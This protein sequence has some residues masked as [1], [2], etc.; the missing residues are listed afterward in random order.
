[1]AVITEEYAE[2]N[3]TNQK[4]AYI[5]QRKRRKTATS[6]SLKAQKPLIIRW[7]IAM[8]YYTSKLQKSVTTSTLLFFRNEQKTHTRDIPG[9]EKWSL[10]WWADLFL[11]LSTMGCDDLLVLGKRHQL[12]F[13]KTLSQDTQVRASTIPDPRDMILF[14]FWDKRYPRKEGTTIP[15]SVMGPLYPRSYGQRYPHESGRTIQSTNRLYYA[16]LVTE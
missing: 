10:Y 9:S 4:P 13:W 16:Y 7:R 8:P 15:T 2:S 14:D 11:R 3:Q 12:Q 6:M 5:N 1:M